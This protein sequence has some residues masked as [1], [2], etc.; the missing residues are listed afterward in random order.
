MIPDGDN[1]KENHCMN[2]VVP[3]LFFLG[4][5]GLN[6]VNECLMRDFLLVSAR[7]S[8]YEWP[9]PFHFISI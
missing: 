5:F 4:S 6:A 2:Q 1:N 7:I 9:I 8:A 3:E